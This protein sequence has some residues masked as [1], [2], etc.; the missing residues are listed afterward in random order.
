[1]ADSARSVNAQAN[2]VRR[3]IVFGAGE[4]A[5]GAHTGKSLLAYELTQVVQQRTGLVPMEKLGNGIGLS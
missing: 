4:Y 5:P 2:T 1:M 3:D